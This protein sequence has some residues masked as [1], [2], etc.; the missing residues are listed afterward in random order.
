MALQRAITTSS[1]QKLDVSQISKLK[2]DKTF[3]RAGG[4]V[5]GANRGTGAAGCLCSVL[6]RA[7]DAAQAV[8]AA[9]PRG[10]EPYS[11]RRRRNSGPHCDACSGRHPHAIPGAFHGSVQRRGFNVRCA[12]LLPG[13]EPAHVRKKWRWKCTEECPFGAFFGPGGHHFCA[14][15]LVKRGKHTELGQQDQGHGGYSPPAM[16]CP[17][18]RFLEDGHC[19]S[20]QKPA[21]R[22]SGK[23]LPRR[24]Q[25]HSELRI[26]ISAPIPSTVTVDIKSTAS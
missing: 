21:V 4:E 24:L 20:T 9:G 18:L 7:Q 1:I 2:R 16:L 12:A 15:P 22:T 10:R 3:V 19:C 13:E 6:L 23:M 25:V 17:L 11:H 8:V 26:C 5:H 14:V